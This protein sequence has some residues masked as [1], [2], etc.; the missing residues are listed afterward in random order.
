MASD[1]ESQ[2][3]SSRTSSQSSRKN[4]KKSWHLLNK[5]FHD[6]QEFSSFLNNFMHTIPLGQQIN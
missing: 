2:S 5:R 6:L 1:D 4:V 3:A